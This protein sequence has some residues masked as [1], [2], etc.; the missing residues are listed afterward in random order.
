MLLEGINTVILYYLRLQRGLTEMIRCTL[1]KCCWPVIT[2]FLFQTDLSVTMKSANKRRFGDKPEWHFRRVSG[3]W[4]V[5]Y[6]I[7]ITIEN[8]AGCSASSSRISRPSYLDANEVDSFPYRA[9]IHVISIP[10][11]HTY[12]NGNK[13]ASRICC[14]SSEIDDTFQGHR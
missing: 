4:W 11:S 6:Q 14:L 3:F 10:V 7:R 13:I 12:Q 9:W 8:T 1:Q 2:S 5:S